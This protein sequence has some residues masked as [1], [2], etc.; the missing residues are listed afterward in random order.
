MV[1]RR[2]GNEIEFREFARWG[3]PL[4]AGVGRVIREELLARGAAAAVQLPGGRRESA[5]ATFELAL[6]VLA[7]EGGR[8]GSVQ[9]LAGW[10]LMAM[11]DGTVTARGDFRADGQRWDGKSEAALAARL[12]EAVA[13]LAGEIAAALAKR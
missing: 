3:E 10:E 6:R 7:A 2:G 8:D 13:A 9:F 5:V 4:E 12:S 11:A 1:V